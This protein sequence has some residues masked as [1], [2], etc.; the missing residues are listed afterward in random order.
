VRLA[1]AD[2]PRATRGARIAAVPLA[3]VALAGAALYGA[4]CVG[5]LGCL[6]DSCS[7]ELGVG[8]SPFW[9]ADGEWRYGAF[10]LGAAVVAAVALVASVLLAR[11]AVRG[12]PPQADSPFI[13]LALAMTLGLLWLAAH[14]SVA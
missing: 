11:L 12:R 6:G 8:D 5:V 1:R 4:T 13:A 3:L 10:G 14:V 7:Y 2:R 9:A